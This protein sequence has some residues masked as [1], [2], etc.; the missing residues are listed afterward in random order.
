MIDRTLAK[1]PT[2]AL[3][4]SVKG[5][6]LG[7]GHP[8]AAIAEFDTALQLD[9]NY[10][11][12]YQNKG[13]ALTL[14][15]RSREA[16]LPLQIAVRLSPKDPSAALM[17]FLLCHAHLHLREYHEAIDECRRS[18]NLNNLFW[19]PYVDLVVAYQAT[20]KLDETK[21]ALVQLYD[22]RPDFTV[23]RYQQL[24]F[25]MSRNPQFRDEITGIFVEGMRKAG[26]REH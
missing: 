11:P 17:R 8:E 1:W 22:L 18:L 16:L 26:V 21:Q 5:D 3:A 23:E 24:V 13:A 25:K 7:F 2:S 19:L 20:G 15:G 14:L 12:A 4:H 10:P 9:P 6:T